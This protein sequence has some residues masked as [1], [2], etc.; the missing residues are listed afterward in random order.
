MGRELRTI[1]LLKSATFAQILYSGIDIDASTVG[2]ARL[3]TMCNRFSSIGVSQDGIRQL[4]GV[5]TTVA[6]ELGH[7]FNMD[8]DDGE[9]FNL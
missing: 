6:H 7:I 5:V 1:A 8:H 9:M 3:G 2:I 4:G